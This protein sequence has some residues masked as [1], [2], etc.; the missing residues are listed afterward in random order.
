MLTWYCQLDD[1][2]AGLVRIGKA[3]GSVKLPAS[4][5]VIDK[6]S[7][8]SEALSTGLNASA[9]QLT[10]PAPATPTPKPG[11]SPAAKSGGFISKL[12]GLFGRG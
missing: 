11:A 1:F 10:T 6:F 9:L 12:K 4:Q 2:D 7:G 5:A 8:M 3:P